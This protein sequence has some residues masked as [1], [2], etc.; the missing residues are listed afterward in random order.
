[1][2]AM[3]NR[4][5]VMTPG[6]AEATFVNSYVDVAKGWVRLVWENNQWNFKGVHK[7]PLHSFTGIWVSA[8]RV[9][10]KTYLIQG[11]LS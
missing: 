11:D 10:P 8:K 2:T 5:A 6:R 9:D 1:M 3:L 4:Y 7:R